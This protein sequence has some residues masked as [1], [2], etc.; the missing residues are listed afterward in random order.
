MPQTLFETAIGLEIHAQL[1]TQSKLFCGDSADYGGEPNTHL[2]ATSLAYPGTLPRLNK[3]A[4]ELALRLGLALGCDINRKSYFER[5]NYFYPDLSKGY[6]IT[7]NALPLCSG[8]ALPIVYDG[9]EK[10][11]ALERIHL[12]EDTAKSF[13]DKE[14]TSI[15]YNRAGVALAEIVSEPVIT[16][17]EE[18]AAALAMIR[19]IVRHLDVCDGNMEEG[20]LRCDANVSVKKKGDSTPGT[21]IEIKN[22]NSVSFLKQAVDFEVARLSEML[23]KGEEIIPETRGYDPDTK[24]TFHLRTKENPDYRFLAEPD[25]PPL[26]ITDHMVKAAKEHLK[27]LPHLVEKQMTEKLGI[28]EQAA[29]LITGNAEMLSVFERAV[30]KADAAS[31][32][33]WLVGPVRQYLNQE[34]PEAIQRLQPEMV[35]ALAQL[36]HSGKVSFFV[37]AEKI[38]PQM[39]ETGNKDA[40]EIAEAKGLFQVTDSDTLNRWVDEVLERLPRQVSNYKNG[41]KNLLGFFLGEVRKLSQGKADMKMVTSIITEKLNN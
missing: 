2:S 17:A 12:E 20:S 5:K 19:R 13:H 26:V 23:E 34:G 31:V 27:P 30:K 35:S 8:G 33:N 18:A 11:I 10:K 41:K 24:R 6:Q 4:V 16:S 1:L 14:F 3:K 9:K 21:K 22:L 29:A 36:T 38:F 39:I 37:A 32:A 15:D 28:S 7:Q 40:F 25:L